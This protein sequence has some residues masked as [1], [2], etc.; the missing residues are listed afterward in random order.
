MKKKRG[1][2]SPGPVPR[3]NPHSAADPPAAGLLLAAGSNQR[4]FLLLT[5]PGTHICQ[6]FSFWPCF[7]S[8]AIVP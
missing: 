8:P 5:F 1:R 3:A 6:P 4:C 2:A 7:P